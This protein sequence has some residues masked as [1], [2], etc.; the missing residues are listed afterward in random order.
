MPTKRRD[1][2]AQKKINLQSRPVSNG[3]RLRATWWMQI[4]WKIFS[5]VPRRLE[6][7]IFRSFNYSCSGIFSEPF[8]FSCNKT[9]KT[10][11][12]LPRGC[13]FACLRLKYRKLLTRVD[14]IAT[15]FEGQVHTDHQQGASKA[16]F[17]WAALK[18][19]FFCDRAGRIHAT[20]ARAWREASSVVVT[21][22][23][24]HRKALSFFTFSSLKRRATSDTEQEESVHVQRRETLSQP[25]SVQSI[26]L[27]NGEGTLAGRVS[28]KIQWNEKVL[29][30]AHPSQDISSVCLQARQRIKEFLSQLFP[31]AHQ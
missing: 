5:L 16:K 12:V 10:F 9:N 11:T 1:T 8:L 22:K 15:A 20:H 27:R 4:V 7:S 31:P 24:E 21:P 6:D 25:L 28:V 13:L 14:W 3:K 19:Y 17:K 29:L 2:N 23:E 30:S 26:T 18:D